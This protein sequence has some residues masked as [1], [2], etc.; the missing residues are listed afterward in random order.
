MR[1]VI[2]LALY[3][4]CSAAWAQGPSR[5]ELHIVLVLD[6]DLHRGANDRA[7]EEMAQGDAPL[8][9]CSV[10]TLKSSKRV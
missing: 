10:T 6:G 7:E 9:I 1:F 8:P 3:A 5:A 2:A 4:L